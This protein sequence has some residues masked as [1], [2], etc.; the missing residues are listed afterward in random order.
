[1]IRIGDQVQ[2]ISK[3]GD[4]VTGTYQGDEEVPGINGPVREHVVSSF[5]AF[6]DD[7]GPDAVLCLVPIGRL[8]PLGDKS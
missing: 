1:M 2:F 4:L 5:N 8:Q 7:S 3:Y 6:G